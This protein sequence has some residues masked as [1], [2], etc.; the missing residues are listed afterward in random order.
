MN[1]SVNQI[2]LHLNGLFAKGIEI[3]N[4]IIGLVVFLTVLISA[5]GVGGGGFFTVI[6]SLIL[7]SISAIVVCGPLAIL[8][9]IRNILQEATRGKKE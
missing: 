9:N 1:K 4:P 2:L 3:L 5:I 7:A 8:T 6:A